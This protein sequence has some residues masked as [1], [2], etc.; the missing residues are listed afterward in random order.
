MFR[1]L[2]SYVN[3]GV[4]ARAQPKALEQQSIYEMQIEYRKELKKIMDHYGIKVDEIDIMPF[5][6]RV[7][8]MCGNQK[9][10]LEYR[11]NRLALIEDHEGRDAGGEARIPFHVE[12]LEQEKEMAAEAKA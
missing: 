11:K 4:S 6:H 12:M 1:S 7:Q 3:E 2:Q 10:F 8:W 9:A 5:E